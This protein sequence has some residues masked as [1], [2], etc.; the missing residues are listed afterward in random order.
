MRMRRG[1]W[2]FVCGYSCGK[3]VFAIGFGSIGFGFGVAAVVGDRWVGL[4]W[5]GV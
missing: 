4:Q 2:C 5:V 3:K 1:G